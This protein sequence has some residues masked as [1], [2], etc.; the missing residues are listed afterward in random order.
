M[1]GGG[2]DLEQHNFFNTMQPCTVESA[3]KVK[4]TIIFTITKIYDL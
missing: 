4:I 3:C 1:R 2:G